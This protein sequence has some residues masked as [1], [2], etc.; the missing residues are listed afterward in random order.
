MAW[1]RFP[2]TSAMPLVLAMASVGPIV[3]VLV[4]GLRLHIRDLLRRFNLI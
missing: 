2:R 3:S 4:V 1:C